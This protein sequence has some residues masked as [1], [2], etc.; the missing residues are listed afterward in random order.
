MATPFLA[1][2]LLSD[3]PP[4]TLYRHDLESFCWSLWWIAVSYLDGNQ[5]RTNELQGWYSGG[6]KQIR[7]VKE[8]SMQPKVVRKEHFT[9]NMEPAKPVLERLAGLFEEV[10]E[11]VGDLETASPEEKKVFDQESAGGVI[12]WERFRA[13]FT[14]D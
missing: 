7:I 1:L 2:E 14:A 3:P 8:G 5:I 4:R 13:C 10:I 12:T 6:W 11:S 9:K